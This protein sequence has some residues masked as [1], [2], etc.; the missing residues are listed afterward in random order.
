MGAEGD[1][2]VQEEKV[3][4]GR[5][6]SESDRSGDAERGMSHRRAPPPERHR[7]VPRG[8]LGKSI[9]AIWYALPEMDVGRSSR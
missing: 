5:S 7:V 9:L 3:Q 8:V 6:G 4:G 1:G 2:S